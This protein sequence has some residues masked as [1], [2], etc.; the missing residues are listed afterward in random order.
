LAVSLQA[1]SRRKARVLAKKSKPQK[2]W[3]QRQRLNAPLKR[4]RE[5]PSAVAERLG[6]SRLLNRREVCA[7][8]NLTYVSIWKR[9]QTDPPSFPRSRIEGGRSVWISSEVEQW[10]SG[11][12]LRRL[13]GDAEKEPA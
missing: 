3:L 8:T 13:K 12:K 4:E 7:L 6:M 2:A 9:M 11:L 1:R 5:Q 10:F